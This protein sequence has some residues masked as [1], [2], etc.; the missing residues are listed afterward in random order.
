[1]VSPRATQRN[2]PAEAWRIMRWR[3]HHWAHREQLA[4]GVALTMLR[5]PAGN[6]E[7]GAPQ[8]EAGSTEQE[9]PVHRVTLGEF[10][11]GQTPI[12]QAQW[13]AVAEWER[14]DHE[15]VDLWP[16]S[17]LHNPAI[18]SDRKR[19][20]GDLRP[21]VNVSW[22]DAQEFCQR[23]A[24]RTGKNYTL[25][26]EA[27]WEYACRA[28][29]ITPFHFGDTISTELANYNGEVYGNGNKGDNR[30]QTTDVASFPANPWG[31]HDM[32]GNVREWCADCW[33]DN[34]EGVPKDVNTGVGGDD[35]QIINKD[36]VNMNM[37][38]LR[39]G[40][41]H[42]HPANCRSA[43]RSFTPSNTRNANIGFRV[44]CLPQD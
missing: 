35:E 8:T 2:Q 29:T 14:L 10:L 32:H 44:C 24:L 34:F 36:R 25:P 40:S 4:E 31:L 13:R 15:P 43:Y 18:T 20:R 27:Q 26:S 39:G 37:R 9:R 41:W 22:F 7:M 19:F 16:E 12:T 17:F 23:L 1:M 11:L 42:Y 30:Q 33:H 38:L 6:F 5:I 3:S 28:G 21:V